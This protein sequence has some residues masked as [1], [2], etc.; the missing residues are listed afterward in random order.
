[1]E[2][3]IMVSHAPAATKNPTDITIMARPKKVCG[4]SHTIKILTN[5]IT[6]KL[7]VNVT[8][9]ILSHSMLLALSNFKAKTVLISSCGC[10]KQSS[11]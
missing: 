8:A 9:L 4:N 3:T 2:L 6:V 1:M 7:N 10:V 5:D 11:I